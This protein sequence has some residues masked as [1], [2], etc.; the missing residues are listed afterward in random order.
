MLSDNDAQDKRMCN[1]LRSSSL[2]LYLY[3]V[4]KENAHESQGPVKT[5]W[6]QFIWLLAVSVLAERPVVTAAPGC[7]SKGL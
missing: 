3:L 7:G 2:P 4:L 5:S 1:F 6:P